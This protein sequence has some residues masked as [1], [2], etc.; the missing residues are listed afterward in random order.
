LK[1]D[2]VEL[3]WANMGFAYRQLPYRFQAEWKDGEWTE[4]GLSEEPTITIEEGATGLHYGQQC[5]EGLKAHTGPD[6]RARI[7]RPQENAARMKGSAE[8]L[9]M[10]PPPEELFLRGVRSCVEANQEHWPPHTVRGASLYIRPLLIGVGHNLGL[11]PASRFVFRVFCSPVGPYFKGGF[12]D[13]SGLRLLVTERD[14]AAPRGVGAFKVGG[15]YAPGLLLHKQ[16]KERGFDELLYF[17][18][19]EHKWLDEAGSANVFGV[20]EGG[21]LVSPLSDS[22]LPSITRRSILTLA[23]ED[24]DLTV[25]RRK[26]GADEIPAFREMG[27]TG[28]ATVITPVRSVTNQEHEV[29]FSDVPGP[30][31]TRLYKRLTGIQRGEIEDTRGWLL[32]V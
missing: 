25:E 21:R 13:S 23:E 4:G 32:S 9:C 12:E 19:L 22:I 30:V 10:P 7:F 6:G 18:A 29:S 11:R 31:S 15:N 17:D 2:T 5:F 1:E 8:R 16:A 3:D 26:V 14:R 24:L 28:T 27:L 20:L